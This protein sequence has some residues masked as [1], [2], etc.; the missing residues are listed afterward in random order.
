LDFHNTS[1]KT[2]EEAKVKDEFRHLDPKTLKLLWH[3]RLSHL[4]FATINHMTKRGE[5]PKKLA[6]CADP[7]CTPC[8]YGQMTRRPWSTRSEPSNIAQQRT[9]TQ[10]GDCVSINQTESPVLGLEAQMKRIPI[11][12]TILRLYFLIITVMLRLYTC[13]NLQMQPRP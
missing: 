9:I 4:L 12:H 3:Y 1:K 2:E 11:P 6:N 13:K 7:M 5:L 10:P 8:I